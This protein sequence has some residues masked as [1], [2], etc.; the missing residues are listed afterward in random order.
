MAGSPQKIVVGNW[1]MH[2][3]IAQTTAF[4]DDLKPLISMPS[5]RYALA[6]PYTAIA[7]AVRHAAGS[8]LLIGA[9]NVNAHV[10]GA[11]TGEISAPMVAE[12]GASFVIVGHSER[13]QLFGET[14]EMVNGKVKS[15]LNNGLQPLLCIGEPLV[16]RL[17]GRTMAY[18]QEQIVQSLSGLSSDQ[19]E[20][21]MI[22]YEPIWAVG[23]NQVASL[24]IIDE[25]H[26][27]CRQ[28]LST[29]WGAAAAKRVPLL[30]GGSV[31]PANSGSLL[32]L[33]AIDGLLVG[34]ASLRPQSFSAIV[35]NNILSGSLS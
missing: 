28:Q 25:V 15:A 29:I 10:E 31:T 18:L 4:I 7:M 22:A 1:K 13:R 14:S 19:L 3:T 33:C 6:V 32:K 2:K 9:Q 17:A 11:Y 20:T 30:Y 24:S 16:E 35:N 34:G 5:C 26:A 21:I 12:A 8:A 27:L 23:T